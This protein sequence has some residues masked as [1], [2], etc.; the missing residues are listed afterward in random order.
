MTSQSAYRNKSRTFQLSISAKGGCASGAKPHWK[1]FD[2]TCS[3]PKQTGGHSGKV[4]DK[5]MKKIKSRAGESKIFRKYQLIGL[6]IADIL[7]D[8]NHVSLYIKLAKQR[9]GE[10]LLEQAKE[11]A[12]RKNIKNKGA[13]FMSVVH[14]P[15]NKNKA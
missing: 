3:S 9:D 6:R 11:V 7:E 5:Y 14:N 15:K 1:D 2:D 12:E 8:K 4:R 13:Y 10:L